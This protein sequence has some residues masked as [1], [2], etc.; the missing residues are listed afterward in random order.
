MI[1][2]K[3][4][5]LAKSLRAAA[6]AATA[7]FLIQCSSSKP[8]DLKGDCRERFAKL[9]ERYEN[10]RWAYAKQG[11]SDFIVTCATTENAEQ[12]HFELATS[13]YNLKEWAEAESEFAAFLK[14]YPNSRRFSEQARW[15]LARSMGK[16]VEIPQRDQTQTLDAI[17]EFET[18][19]AEFPAS[20]QADSAQDELSRLSQLLADR[21]MLI[22]RLYRRMDEP[23]AAAI[24]Y[25]RILKEYG[26]RVPRREVNLLLAE[27]YVELGQFL[28]ADAILQQFDGVA[29][30]DPF[31]EKIDKVRQ[32][33]EKARAKH[34][35]EKRE[36][37]KSAAP[38]N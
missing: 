15:R 25:K 27:S 12:A 32:K 10:G 36:E 28:E 13:H 35:R 18:F 6:L 19:L 37:R 5:F 31:K 34:D 8:K 2:S 23:L 1:V 17:R 3:A 26:D 24:Y 16:Q 20:A 9:H 22:A 14:D 21:D 30:D 7:L 11:Y 4:P 29:K 38:A 33:L